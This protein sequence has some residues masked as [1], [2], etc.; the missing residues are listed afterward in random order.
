MALKKQEVPRGDKTHTQTP[1]LANS[2]HSFGAPQH[3][4]SSRKAILMNFVQQATHANT[5]IKPNTQYTKKG[6]TILYIKAVQGIS[7]K[8]E[9][10]GI[11]KYSDSNI[12]SKTNENLRHHS[13]TP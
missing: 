10:I 1:R 2:S 5:I 4:K 9:I 11:H 6:T 13:A 8:S 7:K 12:S 3:G